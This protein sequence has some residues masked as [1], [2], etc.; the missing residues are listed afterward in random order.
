MKRVVAGALFGATVMMAGA[1]GVALTVPRRSLAAAPVRG[2]L[3][4]A[5]DCRSHQLFRHC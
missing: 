1:A 2:D 4:G 5:S 3:G